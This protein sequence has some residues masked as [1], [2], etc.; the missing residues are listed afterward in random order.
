MSAT[1]RR[2]AAA[3]ARTFSAGAGA[4]VHVPGGDRADGQLLEIRVRGVEEAARLRR[5]EHRHRIRLAARDEVRA[6]E[7]V[8]RDVD[9]DVAWAALADRLADPEHRR[10]VALAFADDDRPVDLDLVERA[11]HRLDRGAVGRRAVAAAH[12]ASRGDRGG[13]GDP[14]HLQCEQRLHRRSSVWA[15][16]RAGCCVM[17]SGPGL[18]ASDGSVVGP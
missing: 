8:D 17:L 7:R 6:L 2:S 3:T 10:L 4:D 14:D 12:Q 15:S 1:E 18:A 16:A 5:G 11:P 9:G 13:L